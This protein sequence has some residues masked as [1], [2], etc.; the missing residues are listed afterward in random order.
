MQL[1]T[2]LFIL[3]YLMSE[4]KKEVRL[5]DKIENSLFSGC[6][7]YLGIDS[8]VN[9]QLWHSGISYRNKQ[10]VLRV[11]T[12]SCYSVPCEI[13]SETE[14]CV[15]EASFQDKHLWVKEA[16]LGRRSRAVMQ[17]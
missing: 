15:Y 4:D 17:L 13:K 8:Q 5:K 11:L 9:R 10:V 6:S 1:F 14:I 12:Q 2:H 7:L 3:K 16:E